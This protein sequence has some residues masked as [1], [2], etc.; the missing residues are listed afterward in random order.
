M[1]KSEFQ[2][3][4]ADLTDLQKAFVLEYAQCNFNGT[5]AA[6]R[7]GY[8]SAN[9]NTL[10]SIASENLR[11]PK[12]RKAID[13]LLAERALAA[14]E[15]LALLSDQARSAYSEYLYMKPVE[16]DEGRVIG[17]TPAFDVERCIADGKGYLIKEIKY[18]DDGKIEYR[19][20]DAQ[21][22]LIQL[23][24]MHELFIDKYQVT[25]TTPVAFTFVPPPP[26]PPNEEA[27]GDGDG[28]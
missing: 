5:E 15:V 27:D 17:R 12:I 8:K 2:R 1:A 14:N 9:R 25:V 23:G 11:K 16:N 13:L 18:K 3:A 7:A 19:F 28:A 10:A 24:K 22:A 26:P 6:A 20:H 4:L 21:T